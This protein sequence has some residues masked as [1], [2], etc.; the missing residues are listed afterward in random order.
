M[1]PS[2]ERDG[3][4]RR[5]PLADDAENQSPS[6]VHNVCTEGIPFKLKGV[7]GLTSDETEPGSLQAYAERIADEVIRAYPGRCTYI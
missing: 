7:K 3:I 4:I 6:N 2:E 5:A 1:S